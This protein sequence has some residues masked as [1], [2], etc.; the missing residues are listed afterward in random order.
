MVSIS[1]FFVYFLK[2]DRFVFI[3]FIEGDPPSEASK[4]FTVI[5]GSCAASDVATLK[6][7]FVNAMTTDVFVQNLYCQNN[8]HCVVKNIRVYCSSVKK[9]STGSSYNA[10]HIS[11]EFYVQDTAPS[12]DQNTEIGKMTQIMNSMGGLAKEVSI[13]FSLLVSFGF[14]SSKRFV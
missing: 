10:V 7:N 9:R 1:T 12:T 14:K 3:Y 6:L 11:F 13:K 5:G 4:P 2:S 8:K